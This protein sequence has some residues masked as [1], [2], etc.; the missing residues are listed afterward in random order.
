MRTQRASAALPLAAVPG[1]TSYNPTWFA[2]TNIYWD[3]AGTSGGSDANTGATSGSPLLTFAEIVR[4][5]GSPTPTM[6]YGQ[7]VTIH[8][9]TSQPTAQDPV[10]FA[11]KISGGGY[12]ALIGTLIPNGPSTTITGLVQKNR[13]LPGGQLQIAEFGAM[14]RGSL[15]FNSTRNSYAW[16]CELAGGVASMS[17]PIPA[18]TLTTIGMPTLA[19]DDTWANGDTVQIVIPPAC[20]LKQFTATGGDVSAGGI[21]S[22]PWCQWIDI[23][24]PSAGGAS[25]FPITPNGSAAIFSSCLFEGRV[26]INGGVGRGLQP[27]HLIGC[28]VASE[29]ELFAGTLNFYGGFIGNTVTQYGGFLAVGGDAFIPGDMQIDGG[30]FAV[31]QNGCAI[32]GPTTFVCGA[33]FVNEAIV[34]GFGSFNIY[35]ES[36]YVNLSGSSFVA[37]HLCTGSLSLGGAL[38][39][40]AY[41]TGTWT[42]GIAITPANLDA[43]GGL[44]N[45]KTG[46]RYCGV[47]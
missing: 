44:Q 13:S 12:V 28:Y 31:V 19:E 35:A 46:A 23:T 33:Q 5:Y 42:D 38:T 16:V 40:T 25:M 7:N 4:R 37:S 45:P 32:N 21:Y 22:L 15:L 6:N 26:Y 1:A 30:C 24:D 36:A 41:S 3:P 11:P 17:Q 8:Q 34:W 43:H 10:F 47:S 39:G 29:L 27:P 20:N 18:S 2:L 9:L 14:V